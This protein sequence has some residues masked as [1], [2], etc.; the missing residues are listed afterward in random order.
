MHSELES[1]R[2]EREFTPDVTQ[3]I[4]PLPVHL[5]PLPAPV[6]LRCLL[7]KVY[8]YHIPGITL[9]PISIH[10]ASL[11]LALTADVTREANRGTTEYVHVTLTAKQARAARL[12]PAVKAHIHIPPR[13]LLTQ[14]LDPLAPPN[15]RSTA[16][17]TSLLHYRAQSETHYSRI[18]LVVSTYLPIIYSSTYLSNTVR[19]PLTGTSGMLRAC[20]D[21]SLWSPPRSCDRLITLCC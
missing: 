10:I 13:L 19:D 4:L 6:S 8:R 7:G 1:E 3:S 17:V 21:V 16:H 12:E 11:A 14:P 15:H 9:S 2:R 5:L 18:S 20:L